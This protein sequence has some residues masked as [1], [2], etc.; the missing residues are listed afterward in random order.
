MRIENC[1]KCEYCKV[2][3]GIGYCL[4]INEDATP[5]PLSDIGGC[6]IYDEEIAKK[7]KVKKGGK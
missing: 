2:I 4:D 7:S 6:G 5:Y 3:E 1:Q